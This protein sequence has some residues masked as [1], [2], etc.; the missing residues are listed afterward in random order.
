MMRSILT[1]PCKWPE[2]CELATAYVPYQDTVEL[3]TPEEAL[4]RGTLFPNLYG[5][6]YSQLGDQS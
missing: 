1:T 2:T 3:Y 5:A 4:K 6:G